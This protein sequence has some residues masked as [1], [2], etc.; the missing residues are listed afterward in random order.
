MPR[1]SKARSVCCG[2][3]RPYRVWRLTLFASGFAGCVIGIASSNRNLAA[4]RLTQRYAYLFLRASSPALIEPRILD[5]NGEVV[6][7]AVMPRLGAGWA[8]RPPV[9]AVLARGA[10]VVEDAELGAQGRCSRWYIWRGNNRSIGF[11]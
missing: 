5:L 8:L 9:A 1:F 11:G 4:D 7:S 6:A 3:D 10:H 2:S